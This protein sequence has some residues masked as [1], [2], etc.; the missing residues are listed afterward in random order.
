MITTIV[1][2]FL[3]IDEQQARTLLKLLTF[4][5]R[6]QQEFKLKEETLNP[7]AIKT[8]ADLIKFLQAVGQE[9]WFQGHNRGQFI[10]SGNEQANRMYYFFFKNFGLTR[11]IPPELKSGNPDVAVILGSTQNQVEFRLK[12]FRKDIHRGISPSSGWVIGLGCNRQLGKLSLDREQESIDELTHLNKELHE[13]NMVDLQVKRTLA[14]FPMLSYL[15]INTTTHTVNVGDSNARATTADTAASLKSWLDKNLLDKNLKKERWVVA[16][17]S[18]APFIIRQQ[19][20]IQ[21]QLGS[22]YQVVGVGPGL[23]ISL[24]EQ[25]LK[26]KISAGAICLGEIARLINTSFCCISAEKMAVYTNTLLIQDELSELNSLCTTC[27]LSMD[28]QNKLLEDYES[29]K[30]SEIAL[31]PT[32]IHSGM[33]SRRRVDVIP[34]EISSEPQEMVIFGLKQPSGL[35][36]RL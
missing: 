11:S 31:N 29:M 6:F 13:A 19:R 33:F 34:K 26:N 28:E 18:N 22:R 7:R 2:D 15:G 35:R 36:L 12:T 24:F 20:D 25:H 21:C 9:A 30:R 4:E 27:G 16:V 23:P 8:Q 10:S 3:R 1:A 32:S 17:Y 5:R 14:N